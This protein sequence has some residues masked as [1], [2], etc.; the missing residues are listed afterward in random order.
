MPWKEVSPMDEKVKFIAAV[1]DGTVSISSL[2]ETFG[3]SRKTGYKWLERYRKEGPEGLLERSRVPHTN[4]NRVGFA[5]ERLILAVRKQ[6]PTWGPRKLLVILEG[7][8]PEIIWP[9]ASTIGSILKKRGLVKPRKKRGGM[10]RFSEPFRGYDHPNAVWCADF[11][12]DFK[13]RDGIRCYPLTISD[14]YS[15]FLLSCKGLSGT[16]T[17]ETK[18]EFE[19]CFREYGLPNAIRTDNGIPFAA[20]SGISLLSM[21]WIKL[22]IFPER[23]HPGKPQEN[24]RH[25]RMHRTLKAEAVYPIRSNMRQ[26]QK[27]F[28]RFRAEYNHDRPHEALGQKPPAKIYKPSLRSYPNRL[29][30]IFYPDHFEIRKVDDGNFY[31]KNQRFFITKSLGGENIGLEPVDDGIWA[32]YFSFVKIGYLNESTKKISRTLKV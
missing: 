17:Y 19:K 13:M 2:C 31:W 15:R 4:P 14:G 1:C 21:W 25:E 5:E 6:H 29:S 12:G 16:R 23:I 22:G 7:S 3:I 26:Q 9:A 32:I 24:G 20:G 11:K 8:H 30:E 10:V 27:A 28:D 18:K